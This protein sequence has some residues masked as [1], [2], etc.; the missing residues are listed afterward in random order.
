VS[1]E[2]SG[3]HSADVSAGERITLSNALVVVSVAGPFLHGHGPAATHWTYVCIAYAIG[4]A[5]QM[6]RGVMSARGISPYVFASANRTTIAPVDDAGQPVA[7]AGGGDWRLTVT[8]TIVA[9]SAASAATFASN[10]ALPGRFNPTGLTG[11][12]TRRGLRPR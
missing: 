2:S 4:R 9:V 12:V 10:P 1:T 7:V 3:V 8:V 11:V 6:T 5:P